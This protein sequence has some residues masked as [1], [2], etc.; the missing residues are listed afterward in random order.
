[1]LRAIA[2]LLEL[3]FE[4]QGLELL[5]KVKK[6]AEVLQLDQL[7]TELKTAKTVA[8][9]AAIINAFCRLKNSGEGG[10]SN[11]AARRR[12]WPGFSEC[13]FKNILIP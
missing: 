10:K 8:E 3:K 13:A 11:R 12:E 6:N 1:M 4:A 7:C 9:A 5:E 2:L